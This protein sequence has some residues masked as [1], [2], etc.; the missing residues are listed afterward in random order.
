MK[1]QDFNHPRTQTPSH[2]FMVYIFPQICNQKWRFLAVAALGLAGQVCHST[3]ERSKF[4]YK[5]HLDDWK[6]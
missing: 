4:K 1:Y 3:L 2:A 6:E 5:E